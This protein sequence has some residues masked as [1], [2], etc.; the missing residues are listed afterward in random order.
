MRPTD[1]SSRDALLDSVLY[2]IETDI[3]DKDFTALKELIALIP[4]ANLA[5]YISEV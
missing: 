5:A 3:A 1:F 2:Q 4:D